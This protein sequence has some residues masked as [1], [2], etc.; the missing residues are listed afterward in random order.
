MEKNYDDLMI[1][2]LYM[3]HCLPV[4]VDQFEKLKAVIDTL[5]LKICN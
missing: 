4:S 5:W 2:N 1:I 3:N